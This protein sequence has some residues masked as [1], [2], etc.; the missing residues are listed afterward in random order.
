M[1]TQSFLKAKQTVVHASFEFVKFGCINTLDGTFQ[2]EVVIESK[3]I[4]EE[5][6]LDKYDP[7]IHW[8]PQ[9]KIENALSPCNDVKYVV[10]NE[11]AQVTIKEIRKYDGV[12]WQQLNLRN[13]S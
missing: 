5:N 7:N 12:F 4:F 6:L 11:K 13:V 8:N 3:W 2:A 1:K 10:I 9:L